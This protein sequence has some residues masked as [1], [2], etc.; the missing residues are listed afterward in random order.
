M[1][2]EEHEANMTT[3]KAAKK[4]KQKAKKPCQEDMKN[5]EITE[6]KSSTKERQW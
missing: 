4:I 5:R 6:W 2:L 3:P 1:A